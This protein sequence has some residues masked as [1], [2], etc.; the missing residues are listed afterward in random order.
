MTGQTVW[1]EEWRAESVFN[2]NSHPWTEERACSSTYQLLMTSSPFSVSHGFTLKLMRLWWLPLL[3]WESKCLWTLRQ[4]VRADEPTLILMLLTKD[5]LFFN[6]LYNCRELR[7]YKCKLQTISPC[8]P[9][10]VHAS[11]GAYRRVSSSRRL[12]ALMFG[13]GFFVK[14]GATPPPQL[15][16]TSLYTM[17]YSY[18]PRVI[19]SCS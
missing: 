4:L 12:S 18:L 14:W 6:L 17:V 16:A 11:K 9:I 13:V 5:G 7:N 8:S 19:S 3:P 2:M 1:R 15:S 10:R